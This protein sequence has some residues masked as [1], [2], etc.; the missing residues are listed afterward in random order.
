M[1]SLLI[2]YLLC[3][4]IC[5][6]RTQQAYTSTEERESGT[7]KCAPGEPSD[8]CC[9]T[10]GCICAKRSLGRAAL[11]KDPFPTWPNGGPV[12]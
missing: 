4:S 5:T 9:A 10:Q 6:Q 3:T 11:N 2:P 12:T 1:F 8:R 7:A